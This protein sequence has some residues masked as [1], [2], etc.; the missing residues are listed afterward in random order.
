[1]RPNSQ[2]HKLKSSH[3]TEREFGG[4]LGESQQTKPPSRHHD[5]IQCLVQDVLPPSITMFLCLKIVNAES[6]FSSHSVAY[7]LLFRTNYCT[8]KVNLK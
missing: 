3:G 8:S 6:T 1:M 2:A 7:S 5:I 4:T